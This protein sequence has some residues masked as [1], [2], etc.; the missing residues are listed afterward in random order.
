MAE[1]QAQEEELRYPYAV[2][3]AR[4]YCS[5]GSHIRKL[6]MPASH[7]SKIRDKAMLHEQDCKVGIDQNIPPFG[8]CYSPENTEIDIEITDLLTTDKRFKEGSRWTNAQH[9][10][11]M[12]GSPWDRY[13]RNAPI[14]FK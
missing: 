9:R 6:D 2:R 13:R 10:A 7:G 8:A 12:S 14:L 3:G 1:E 4:I 5:F 11:G